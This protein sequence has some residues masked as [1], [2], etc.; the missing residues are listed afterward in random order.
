MNQRP[1]KGGA[2]DLE[3]LGNL[4]PVLAALVA[5]AESGR[6]AFPPILLL[7]AAGTPGRRVLEPNSSTANMGN[8][9]ATG[10]GERDDAG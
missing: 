3:T 10:S 7:P 5:T 6:A 4:A 1:V 9:E 8:F 2:V